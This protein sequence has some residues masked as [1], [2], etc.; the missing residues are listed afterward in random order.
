[1]M[2][3]PVL[4]P[5]LHSS[6]AEA[7]RDF[8]TKPVPL[9]G[10][11]RVSVRRAATRVCQSDRVESVTGYQY[12]GA[13]AIRARVLL[14]DPRSVAGI[15]RRRRV[16]CIRW[17]A[18]GPW[19][20]DDVVALMDVAIDGREE[21]F[22]TDGKLSN[23][24]A[25][26]VVR[27]L[28]DPPLYMADRS[29]APARILRLE[30]L[31][32]SPARYRSVVADSGEQLWSVYFDT[33]RRK[34]ARYGFEVENVRPWTP[35][36]K[37]P[38]ELSS[39]A[40]RDRVAG[41]YSF[42]DFDALVVPGAD[43]PLVI[44]LTPKIK[45][46]VGPDRMRTRRFPVSAYQLSGEDLVFT[47]L[48]PD[49]RQRFDSTVLPRNIRERLDRW[50]KE[51]ELIPLALQFAGRPLPSADELAGKLAGADDRTASRFWFELGHLALERDDEASARE[52]FARSLTRQYSG[53][54]T[55]PKSWYS[56]LM[57]ADGAARRLEMERSVTLAQGVWR[58]VSVCR[59]LLACL[60][61]VL[62][63][64][65][66][67]YLVIRGRR[68]LSLGTLMLLVVIHC[69]LF[70]VF[71]VQQHGRQYGSPFVVANLIY[72]HSWLGF[73]MSGLSVMFIPFL[74]LWPFCFAAGC[75]ELLVTLL[76]LILLRLRQASGICRRPFL[77]YGAQVGVVALK[78]CLMM[79]WA[80]AMSS[81]WA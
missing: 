43:G 78:Y 81:G 57:V 74:Y 64:L 17:Q 4:S 19:Q 80:R 76:P 73:F 21:T 36:V 48:P 13:T 16:E 44:L 28:H 32:V 25:E 7:P 59:F 54:L 46:P 61:Y 45:M 38:V 68:R 71:L 79:A 22:E 49:I 18:G 23:G 15:Q 27:F 65:P 1:M 24:V 42:I 12:A 47:T 33:T 6:A 31:Q 69:V 3:G 30:R 60:A 11:A 72:G 51:P 58:R 40:L 70:N 56:S 35:K 52:A 50:N 75:V 39:Q 77:W 63:V 41:R 34:D 10:Q 55:L 26:T 14:H 5:A 20:C 8:I 37:P 53:R 2:L 66:V 29:F 67:L 62:P 9:G